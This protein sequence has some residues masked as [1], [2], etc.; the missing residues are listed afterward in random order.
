MQLFWKNKGGPSLV[1]E[2][3]KIYFRLPLSDFFVWVA[4]IA[5]LGRQIFQDNGTGHFFNSSVIF[6]KTPI[7]AHLT[8]HYLVIN[9]I[10]Y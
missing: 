8:T 1:G 10:C 4:P 6:R 3:A 2:R 9:S 7:A 5:T